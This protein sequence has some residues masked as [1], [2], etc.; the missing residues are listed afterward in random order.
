MAMNNINQFLLMEQL[1]AGA[2]DPQAASLQVVIQGSRFLLSDTQ[3]PRT[4][5]MSSASSLQ[6]E[7]PP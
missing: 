5:G 1:D 6:W 2:S 3:P 7:N 4:S